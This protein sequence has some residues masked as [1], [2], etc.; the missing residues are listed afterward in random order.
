[1][2]YD[3]QMPRRMRKS[4]A[5]SAYYES[6]T[7]EEREDERL[8]AEFAETQFSLDL[9]CELPRDLSSPPGGL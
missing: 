5:I 9:A 4:S 7:D 2:S 3:L 1:M 8:W 6:L